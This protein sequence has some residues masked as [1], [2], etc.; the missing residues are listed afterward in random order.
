MLHY[1]ENYKNRIKDNILNS[2]IFY[3]FNK[4]RI[5]CLIYCKSEK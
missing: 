3:C 2:H 4:I 1:I 5:Y